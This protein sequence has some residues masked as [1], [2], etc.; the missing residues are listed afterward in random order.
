[1]QDLNSK[2]MCTALKLSVMAVGF[3]LA[4]GAAHAAIPSLGADG[5]AGVGVNNLGQK[6][7]TGGYGAMAVKTYTVTNRN[8][9]IQALYGGTAVIK[10]D[11][12]FSGTLDNSRKV[13]YI[14][15][16]ISLNMNQALQELTGDDHLA[17]ANVGSAACSN[18]GYTSYDTWWS[19]YLNAYKPPYATL[20]SGVPE[21]V[22][23][24]GGNQ[25]RKI[26]RITIPSNTSLIGIGASARIIHGN[27]LVSGTGAA[28]PVDNIVIRNI[29][30]EDAFDFFPQWDPTDSGGR[31]NS[32]YDNVSVQHATHVWVDHCTFSDGA[33]TDDKFP[34]VWAAP[35]DASQ[36]EVEH[37][38]GLVDVTAS[39]NYV[40]LSYN[41]F[42]DHNKT[43]LI[44]GSDTA[45]LTDNNPAVL[46]TTLHHNYYQN[47]VQRM[48]RVRY[49]MVHI[50]NNYYTGANGGAD[51]GWSVGWASGQGSK[52][53]AE[54]NVFNITGK[55]AAVNK[56]ITT[57]VS[58]SKVGGCAALAGMSTEYCSA[59]VYD[60][61]TVLNGVSVNASDAAHSQNAL[62][63]A[64]ATPWPSPASPETRPSA[65]PSS[66]Y[67]YNVG[68]TSG[69]ATSVPAGAGVG[70][71]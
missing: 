54:N 24:C 16:T 6:G 39:A 1:M 30:F 46:K 28:S 7:T 64:T 58:S 47:V 69:L 27:L 49:G 23:A 70:K 21:A 55:A 66:Y 32:T 10:A 45:S 26:V 5:W 34:S 9:L 61:G 44:G 36:Y 2:A 15:G 13:I 65:T 62:V 19:A 17:A 43:S 51:Y 68:T 22:R 20:P 29:A 3:A 71:L 12:S 40:T 38:D 60:T 63:T 31:W 35:Y 50:Y 14:S 57:S 8:G 59:Y 56:V 48:P 33:R 37:H 11:G 42:H 41:H 25:Q 4:G 53:Y 67:N 18:Y 52:I